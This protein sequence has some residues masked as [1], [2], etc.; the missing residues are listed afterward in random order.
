MG[1]HAGVHGFGERADLADVSY[2]ARDAYVGTGVRNARPL[3]VLGKLPDRRVTFACRHGY[4]RTN[5]ESPQRHHAVRRYRVLD[6][7]RT[8][9]YELLAQH[10]GV[11]GCHV[12]VKLDAEVDLTTRRSRGWRRN[13]LQ[14]RL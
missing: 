14:G 6:E 10:Q 9:R 1:E 8:E 3:E 12:A 11:A 7:Q 4:R 2:P 5:G 13:E